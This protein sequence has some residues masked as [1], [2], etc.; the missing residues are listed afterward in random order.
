MANRT[1]FIIFLFGFLASGL[2]SA[3]ES[4]PENQ[5]TEKIRGTRFI[6]SPNYTGKPYLND[7]F[8]LGEIEFTDGTKLENIGLNYST[9]RDELIYYNTVTSA[10][11]QI[12]KISLNGFSFTD[13]TG[14]KRIFR[15]QYCS[16]SLQS[17]CYFERLSEG[18]T[19]LLVYRKVNL[20]SCDTYYS[21]SGLAYQ[22]AFI[23]YLYSKERGYSPVNMNRSSLLSKFD[24]P[25]QKLV[26]KLLRKNGI[27]ISDE[28]TLVNAWNLI[29]EQG[30]EVN[31]GN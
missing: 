17:E 28:E 29:S 23:Y 8:I 25:N 12:D 18:K 27:Y 2:L 9:Y 5:R 13:K 15:R 3:R 7:K 11:I 22:P 6:P 14:A 31:F 24:K 4:G 19:A 30:I 21:K 26:K 10:Q 20:E 1:L 16:G